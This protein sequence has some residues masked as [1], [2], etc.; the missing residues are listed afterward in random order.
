MPDRGVNACCSSLWKLTLNPPNVFS[1]D[2]CFVVRKKVVGEHAL[3]VGA[4]TKD[5]DAIVSREARHL[6]LVPWR[7]STQ[8]GVW[9]VVMPNIPDRVYVAEKEIE[10][11]IDEVNTGYPAAELTLDDVAVWNAGLVLFGANEPGNVNLS[12]GKRSRL[13]DHQQVHGVENLVSLVGVR[14]T[15]ARSEAEVKRFVWCVTKLDLHVAKSRTHATILPGGS[16]D[17]FASLL[18]EAKR[19]APGNDYARLS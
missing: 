3:A 6:F 5:P 8:V 9:H 14:F 17:S 12:Y 2:A 10:Q 18:D 19:T 13:V 11:F 4:Q 1:R 15:T 7:E 16:F